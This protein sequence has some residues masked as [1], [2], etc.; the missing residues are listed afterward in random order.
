MRRV[1]LGLL[2][3][4]IGLTVAGSLGRYAMAKVE[5]RNL[6]LVQ[7]TIEPLEQVSLYGLEL[8]RLGSEASPRRMDSLEAAYAGTYLDSG[9]VELFGRL[10][11]ARRSFQAGPTDSV[12]ARV[13]AEAFRKVLRKN[14]N[15]ARSLS[16][17]NGA[18]ADLAGWGI[19]L[20][21]LVGAFICLSYVFASE[22]GEKVRGERED[23]AL[24]LIESAPDAIVIVDQDADRIIVANPT[25]EQLLGL[26]SNELGRM[27]SLLF[28][29]PNQ[30]D[31]RASS[32]A[33]EAAIKKVLKGERLVVP[34]TIS[35]SDGRS[36][37]CEARLSLLPVAGRK[38]IRASFLDVTERDA[39]QQALA[40][41]EARFRTLVEDSSIAI[42]ISIGGLP[43]YVNKACLELF[44]YEDRE[45]LLAIPVRETYHPDQRPMLDRRIQ[46]RARGGM[47]SPDYGT[48]CLRKD[49]T[50]FH[51][52]IWTTFE[53]R[54]EGETVVGFLVDTTE[55]VK[56]RESLARSEARFR[57]LVEDSSIAIRISSGERMLYANQACIDLFGYPDLESFL[58]IPSLDT[59]HPEDRDSI[60]ERF[61]IRARGGEPPREFDGKC[62]RNDGTHFHVHVSTAFVNLE[63]GEAVVGFLV[64]T[65]ESVHAAEREILQRE[66]LIH[67][68]RM[69]SLGVLLAGMA[70]EINNPNNLAL[71]NADLLGRILSDAEPILDAYAQAHP[72][73]RL[74]G[75][76]YDEMKPEV[77]ALVEGIRGGALRIRDI[78]AGL[79][80]F[81]RRNP[82]SDHRAVEPTQIVQSSLLLVG[83][84]VRKSTDRFETDLAQGL[85]KVRGDAQQLEQVV[86]NLLTNACQALPARDRLLAVRTKLSAQGFVE[87]EV[88]D[89]G[90]GIPAENHSKILDPF[91]TTKR[92]EGGTGLGLS[93]SWAIVQAHRGEMSFLPRTGG[94]T[95][96]VVRLPVAPMEEPS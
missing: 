57:T 21:A 94:G 35:S 8:G 82:L 54:D 69:A 92:E 42:R 40:K 23:L 12:R 43:V 37:P 36:I 62:V 55:S 9:D 39:S 80:D 50:P 34:W 28:S 25:A 87:I 47:P 96:V 60:A 44:G 65:T 41:S 4:A 22:R 18:S 11:A 77:H 84:L 71:F 2:A 26:S 24:S 63:E 78:I 68:D 15:E 20:V 46:L 49:G 33:R 93:V 90:V 85:P 29:P 89:E 7:K 16:L 79:K 48:I 76:P 17:A 19:L 70:H 10:R 31:G 45:S 58:G 56:A 53:Q 72:G 13:A 88:E 61:A 91:F 5:A 14:G 64:D 73:F 83:N 6:R 1:R 32:Q 3:L 59:Y 51:A 74:S 27:E 75:I 30:P 52:Q 95:R 67:A 66:Q 38:L 86:V 81:S